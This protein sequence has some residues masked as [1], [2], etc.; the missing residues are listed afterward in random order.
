MPAFEYLALDS[1]GREKKGVL[2]ADTARLARSQLRAQ[3]LTPLEVSETTVRQSQTS[4]SKSRAFRGSLSTADLS[5]IT[6][7][8]A[9]LTGSGTPL[10]EA[11]LA[12]SKQT[13][14]QK[15]KSLILSVRAKVLEGHSL[16]AALKDYPRVFPEI[17]QATVAAGEQSG[18]LDAVLE[19][20]ADYLENR[21][22]TQ[23]TVKKAL[24]YP[25]M[26]VVAS[27]GIVFF[28]LG[29]VVPQVVQVF[30]SMNQELPVLT[31]AMLAA[32]MLSVL[33]NCDALKP[34]IS[35]ERIGKRNSRVC[36]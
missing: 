16:A 31:R 22:A 14:K 1:S 30:E 21:Q 35:R 25:S 27:V 33:A 24:I 6:R 13:E 3:N 2:E 17:Y 23:A 4:T 32:S 29:Y 15:I 28:L 36:T 20:L 18:H 8:I 12:V 9:T 7:Q 19:R 10:E 11:L 5:L 34:L 26:L